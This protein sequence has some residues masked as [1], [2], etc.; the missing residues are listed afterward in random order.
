M[1]SSALRAAAAHIHRRTADGAPPA[2]QRLALASLRSALD[3]RSRDTRWALHPDGVLGRA[4][5]VEGG[6][7]ATFPLRLKAPVTFAARSMLLPHDWRDGSGTVRPWVAVADAAGQRKL[8]AESLVASDRGRPR[9]HP[10]QVMLPATTRALTLGVDVADAEDPRSL[11]RAI[12]LEPALFDPTAPSALSPSPPTTP[13]TVGDPLIS[14]LMPVHD[15][16]LAMLTEAIASVH[17]QTYPRWELCLVDDGSSNP[18]IAAALEHAATIDPRVRLIRHETP[19]GISAATNAALA[20]ATGDYV[21]LLDHDDVL[22][23]DA[24]REVADRIAAQPGLD[25]VYSDEAVVTEDGQLIEHHPKPG[26]SPEHMAALMYTCHLG[27]YRRHLATE[28]GGF[29]TR[30]D[31]CQDYDFVLRLVEQGGRVAHVPRILYHWR[32]HASSTAG[33]DQAKPY[34]YLAQPGAISEHLQRSGIDADVQ[35]GPSPGLHRI[36]HR[37]N[38]ADTVDLVLAIRTIDGLAQ[39]AASWQA[40]PHPAWRLILAAAPELLPSALAVLRDTGLTT[41]RL[42]TVATD[43]D[44]AEAMA[45]AAATATADHLLLIEQPAIGLTRDWLTRLLGYSQ[46]PHIAAAGPVILAPD[47]RIQHAGIAIPEGIPLYLHHGD[48]ARA[49]PPVVYNLSAVTGM[50]CTRRQVHERLGGLH[51]EHHELALIDY[52]LRAGDHGD[53]A[54]IVPDARLR[55]TGPDPA[56][57]DLPALWNLRADWSSTHKTDPYYNPNYRTDRGDY[58]L[59]RYD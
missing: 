30:F 31:G 25:M 32:A 27:V 36:V 21:A 35:F 1:I 34:A 22:I 29:Q 18:R 33:G 49:A 10:V 2:G 20:R 50:V 26:W 12:W 48:D 42:T 16:P 39:A 11:E 23:P 54:V 40:Q 15:P 28:V 47:G 43:A 3:E 51:P 13:P 19:R 53:R 55:T 57:N 5:V 59:R 44:W 9:G 14:V 52:C 58:V 4:L 17:A 8:W 56:T 37:V 38:P 46:Q 45:T 41:D 6:A 7:A 24:L